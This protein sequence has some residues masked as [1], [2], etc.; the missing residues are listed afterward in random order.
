[1]KPV[2]A[3]I[4]IFL[5]LSAAAQP[6]YNA[7]LLD[8]LKQIA[9][10]P[11][12]ARHFA[13]LYY[14]AIEIT[15]A[16]AD[17]LPENKKQFIFGFESYFGP[18]FFRSYKNYIS[19]Q[20]QQ[21]SWQRYYADST[22]NELQFQFMGMNAHIN[23]DM[24]RALKDK[25]PYDTLV[26]Y[27]I[28]LIRFQKVFNTYFDSIYSGSGRCKKI[29]RLHLYTLGM[30]KYIGRYLILH[31]R[32]RQVRFAML[33]YSNPARCERRWQNIQKRMLHYDR[34]AKK[35]IR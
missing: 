29:H 27:R 33:F 16:F 19:Q 20:P 13:K 7:N 15:N 11:T 18:A 32:K 10:S 12:P 28:T 26:K 1:M 22:K 35:W 5:S 6:R 3:F 25:Y 17:T 34:F 14:R 31:W 8:T 24:W 9:N 30:D 23:G 21:F 4:F 2:F